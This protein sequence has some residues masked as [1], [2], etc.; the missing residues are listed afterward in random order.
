MTNTHELT[1]DELEA[2]MA[3]IE[4][5]ACPAVVT[6][7]MNEAQKDAPDMNVLSRVIASDV[8]MSAFAIKLA[9]STLFRRGEPV[10][11]VAQAVTRLGTRN[12]VCIVVAVALRNALSGDL[13]ADVLERFW[14][15]AGAT[16]MAAG[17]TARKLRG[18]QPDTAYTYALFHDAAMPVM[19]R[20]FKDYIGLLDKAA[21]EGTPIVAEENRR[22]HCTHAV[23]GGLLARNW[24]LPATI[25]SAI[26]NHHEPQLYGPGNPFLDDA[27]LALVAV[28]HVAEHLL[29]A[30]RNQADQEV[31]ELFEPAV[32]YL[33]LSED[34]L[35]DLREA[36]AE[37]QG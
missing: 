30:L 36:L 27:S 20:R 15:H 25:A 10:N 6:Q 35:H 11:S 4:I 22:Y 29:A 28:T 32:T 24:G 9:N 2:V 33:G 3:S 16:A 8:G 13:P 17:I 7:V 19:M 12:I 14:N 23:V 26:R 31:G 34:D 21:D 37:V 5:P 18:I 1:H